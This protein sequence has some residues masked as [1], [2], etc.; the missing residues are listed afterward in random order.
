MFSLQQ[1]LFTLSKI[2]H[3]YIKA[4]FK[5]FQEV[6]VPKKKIEEVNYENGNL[7][8]GELLNGKRH[9]YGEMT[10]SDQSVYKGQW[11]DNKRTG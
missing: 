10:F 5:E 2:Y 11:K 9:G 4:Q 8:K 3:D 1:R 6:E 7:Y